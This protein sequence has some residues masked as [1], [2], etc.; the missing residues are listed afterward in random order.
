MGGA[1]V[2]V[3]KFSFQVN[4]LICQQ[5]KLICV[6]DS[7]QSAVE[8]MQ[9]SFNAVVSLKLV[10]NQTKTQLMLLSRARDTGHNSHN[11]Q[12]ISSQH[13]SGSII[14]KVSEYNY[15]VI[16]LDEKLTSKSHIDN[17]MLQKPPSA[18][19][20]KYHKGC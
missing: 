5:H 14:D 1:E 11:S 3:V 2:D 20:L 15:L 16:W 19:Q 10:L 7:A 12:C 6:A 13:I 18:V 17:C 9:L 4:L 8:K